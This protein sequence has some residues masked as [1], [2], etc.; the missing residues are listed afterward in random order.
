MARNREFGSG[1]LTIPGNSEHRVVLLLI[2]RRNVFSMHAT[3]KT[4]ASESE[5]CRP[6]PRSSALSQ[7]LSFTPAT[8]VKVLPPRCELKLKILCGE[9]PKFVATIPCTWSSNV[10][11]EK[12]AVYYPQ[13]RREAHQSLEPSVRRNI[14]RR[15]RTRT[16]L[17][18]SKKRRHDAELGALC[19]GRF[20]LPP[21]IPIERHTYDPTHSTSPICK[22]QLSP[23]FACR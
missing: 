15:R 13:R 18:M 12:T 16:H 21:S 23:E 19:V 3:L 5:H 11:F 22:L 14:I 9:N 2:H 8:N 10:E 6:S 20:H 17:P 1:N 7:Y 4:E